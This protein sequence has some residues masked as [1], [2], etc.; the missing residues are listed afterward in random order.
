MDVVIQLNR[1]ANDAMSD[2]YVTIFV[3]TIQFR[4]EIFK[5]IW[6]AIQVEINDASW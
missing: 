6:S 2:E 4:S 5:M 3:K 1:V